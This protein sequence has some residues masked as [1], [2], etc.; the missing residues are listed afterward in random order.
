[1]SIHF[2][3]YSLNL[4][5]YYTLFFSYGSQICKNNEAEI[6]KNLRTYQEHFVGLEGKKQKNKLMMI[7]ISFKHF[8]IQE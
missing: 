7:N 4:L 6:G 3:R 5:W 2:L 1:M 8:P